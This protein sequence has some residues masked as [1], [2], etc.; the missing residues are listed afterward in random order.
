MDL[1][2]A[3]KLYGI[4]TMEEVADNYAKLK[5]KKAVEIETHEHKIINYAFVELTTIE[6][7]CNDINNIL[8]IKSYVGSE[9]YVSCQR[10]TLYIS[11]SGK[12]R[13][14][15]FRI[16]N[17]DQSILQTDGKDDEI[18]QFIKIQFF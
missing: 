11:L 10:G 16:N 3:K 5:N 1:N 14:L 9:C 15:Y 17:I 6:N 4:Q 12:E 18:K 8:W 2:D 13:Y 7:L